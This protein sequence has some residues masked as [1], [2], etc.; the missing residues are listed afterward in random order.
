MKTG[1]I[2]SRLS[3][4]EIGAVTSLAGSAGLSHWSTEAYLEELA[5][6]DSITLEEW[7]F[8]RQ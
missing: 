1:V 6:P 4:S 7:S 8:R 5:K 3:E 2:V